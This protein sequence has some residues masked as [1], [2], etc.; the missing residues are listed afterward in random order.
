M[1]SD[2]HTRPLL[3]QPPLTGLVLGRFFTDFPLGRPE[4]WDMVAYKDHVLASDMT[5]GFYSLRYDDSPLPLC[6]DTRLPRSVLS[7]KRSSLRRRA[8][9]CAATRP[10]RAAAP[11][12]TTRKRPGAVRRVSVAVARKA[13][14]RCRFVGAKGTL[15]RARKCATRQF[16]T[17]KGTRRWSLSLRGRFPAGSYEISVRARDGAGNRERT[18]TVRLT[19][20]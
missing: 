9:C 2:E 11:R 6:A 17:A 4:I 13:G 1:P 19:L 14:G 20:R 3:G 16:M 7:R 5:G 18:Q 8:S 15:G 10:T 12:P